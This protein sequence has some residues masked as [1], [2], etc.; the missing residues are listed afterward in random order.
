MVDP[1]QAQNGGDRD[2]FVSV[3]PGSGQALSFS[4]YLGGTGRDTGVGVATNYQADTLSGRLYQ[5][6]DFPVTGGVVQPVRMGRH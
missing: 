1:V 6:D 5:A 2:L 3:L 4:S